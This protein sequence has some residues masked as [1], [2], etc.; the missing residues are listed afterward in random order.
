MTRKR[1]PTLIDLVLAHI[2]QKIE[3]LKEERA[4]ILALQA[5]EQTARERPK[6]T[7][8]TSNRRPPLERPTDAIP[9]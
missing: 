6:P 1:S 9:N 4:D 5:R 8:P 3:F 2:D 7:R